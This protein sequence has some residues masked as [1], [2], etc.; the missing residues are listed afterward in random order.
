MRAAVAIR[1][2]VGWTMTRLRVGIEAVDGG[3]PLVEVGDLLLQLVILGV[4][5]QCLHPGKEKRKERLELG[6]VQI[7]GQMEEHQDQLR[8]DSDLGFGVCHQTLPLLVRD[9]GICVGRYSGG[10]SLRLGQERVLPRCCLR[11]DSRRILGARGAGE[12][13]LPLTEPVLCHHGVELCLG[14]DAEHFLVPAAHTATEGRVIN[15]ISLTSDLRIFA[16]IWRLRPNRLGG[17]VRELKW[18]IRLL[19]RSRGLRK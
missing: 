9:L 15:R 16:D 7:R 6:V 8:P 5:C 4:L 1:W 12:R 14:R 18:L 2:L 3:D 19:R 10:G 13:S 11:V 17:K